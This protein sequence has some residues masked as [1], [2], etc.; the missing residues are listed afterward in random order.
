MTFTF[1]IPRR[2]ALLSA[3]VIL[4]GSGM[5]SGA[6]LGTYLGEVTGVGILLIG[7]FIAYSAHQKQKKMNLAKPAS[8]VK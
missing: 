7:V 5:I 6:A 3:L 1:S 8:E 2:D 4:V